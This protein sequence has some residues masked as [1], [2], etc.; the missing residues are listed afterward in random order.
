MTIDWDIIDKYFNDNPNVLVSHHLDTY[1]DFFNQGLKN[2]FKERNPITILK[3]QDP[4]TRDFRLVCELYLG[5]RDGDK[6][7]YGKPIIYDDNNTH[8]MFPNEARLRNMNYGFSVHYDVD[9]VFKIKLSDDP[10]A[11]PEEHTMT[12]DKIF[13]GRFPIMLMSNMCVLQGM[14]RE[15]RFHV[16][17]C[18]NDP[19]GYFIVDGKEKVVVCQEKFAD[20]ILIVK[21]KVNDLYSHAA[22]IRSVSEDA[23]K[24][25]RTTGVRLV[26]PIPTQR[27]KQIVVNIPNVRKPMPLFI[28]FRAL[29]II[30]DK[31]IIQACLLDLDKNENYMELFIPSIHDAN[32]IF[33]QDVALK[34]IATF[35][36]GKTVS[37]VLD[38]L[39]NYF[40]PHIGE[41]NFRDK[42]LF[43]GHMVFKMLRVAT[44]EEKPTDRDSF[45][46]KRIETTG[47]LMYDLF[48]E[49]YTI[50]QRNIYKK[51]DKEYYY[52]EAQYQGMKFLQLIENN[53]REFFKERDVEVGFRKAFKGNWGAEAHTKRAGIVQ[54]LNRLSFNSA[55]AQRR[56]TNLPM[57]ASAKIVA[58]RL[59]HGSQWGVI[60]PLDT[61]DGGNVGLHKHLAISTSITNGFSSAPIIEW[62]RNIGNMK[63]L[64]E[65]TIDFIATYTKVFVN[66]A[67]VGNIENPLDLMGM[68]RIYTR[69]AL[70]QIFMS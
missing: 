1:N 67:W 15:A 4:Q 40:L 11:S 16:G 6:I 49:Y 3:Q 70:L 60:D 59:L 52:H 69:N 13:L 9:V 7:Y 62:L 17:E 38:I 21:D 46:F 64:E 36:K 25:I 34:Y 51:I 24:P 55:L 32:F 45:A 8:F 33:D 41:L 66:G 35:T 10:N 20:N 26:A 56:K 29:G 31:D 2:I 30:S 5:G 65:S 61:P 44:K 12:L 50:M 54:D 23:S 37:H 57:E 28:V 22:E 68:I 27:N 43:L 58:P 42:A 18:K 53:Y 47:K 48:K 14:D 63:T 19:G 39:M